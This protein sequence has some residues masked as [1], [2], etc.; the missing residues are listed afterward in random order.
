M[1]E[2]LRDT[3]VEGP[4]LKGVPMHLKKLMG[5]K[6]AHLKKL[7]HFKKS[8]HFKWDDGATTLLLVGI[9]VSAAVMLSAALRTVQPTN[10][11]APNAAA[12]T[13]VT[14][15]KTERAQIAPAPLAPAPNAQAD[16]SSSKAGVQQQAA[17]TLTGC[18][19]QSKD[20]FRLK[21]TTGE[22]APKARS[23]KSGFLKKK[24]PSIEVIDRANSM[25]LSRHVGERVV[26]TG[27][28]IDREMQVRS[29]RRVASS[30][31]EA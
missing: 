25:Q 27:L 19:E 23:W 3:F 30:C 6:F 10:A 2:V 29:L 15:V 21:D 31:E 22:N 1:R 18:L 5:K 11:A 17:V 14:P 20:A 16:K 8:A 9:G 4:C 13:T 26:V 12:K 24:T 7:A 28:L